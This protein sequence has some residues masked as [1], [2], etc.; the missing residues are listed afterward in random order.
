MSE[1]DEKILDEIIA[2]LARIG[3]PLDED[4]KEP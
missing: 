2:T 3:G 4:E 1:H